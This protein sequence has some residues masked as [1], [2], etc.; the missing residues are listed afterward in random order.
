M[1]TASPVRRG[2][3]PCRE[4]GSVS[5]HWHDESAARLPKARR[6]HDTG[7][8]VQT[9]RPAG[10]KWRA[11]TVLGAAAVTIALAVI[12]VAALSACGGSSVAGTYKYD[13]GSETAMADFKLTLNDDETMALS[14][15]NPLG[16]DDLTIKGAYAVDGD[17][18]SLKDD[19]GVES[20][21]GTV[22]GDRLVFE[23]VTWVKE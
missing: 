17:Q 1:E 5:E 20:E 8:H 6:A 23:T 18:I 9:S 19:K 21:A 12:L 10:R 11:P 3:K 15:P 14:G 13:S 16:G 7:G 2:D 22:D 4:H